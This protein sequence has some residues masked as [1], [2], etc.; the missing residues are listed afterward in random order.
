MAH[1]QFQQG[2]PGPWLMALGLVPGT[3]VLEQGG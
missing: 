3:K 1:Y 2:Q